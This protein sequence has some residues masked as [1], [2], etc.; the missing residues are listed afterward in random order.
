MNSYTRRT[1]MVSLQD[2][3]M[4]VLYAFF[5]LYSVGNAIGLSIPY[6]YIFTIAIVIA[7]IMF[8]KNTECLA[9]YKG[10][11]LWQGVFIFLMACSALWTINTTH[12]H[13]Q[14]LVMFKI[15]LKITTVVII[16]GDFQGVQKLLA[17]FSG[18]GLAIFMTLFATGR[19]YEGWRLGTDLLG[20][21]NSF[22]HIVTIMMTG[23][24]Y[25]IFASRRRFYKMVNVVIMALDLY[26]IFLSGGRKFII[27]AVVFMFVTIVMNSD[28]VRIRNVV[29]A[30]LTIAILVVIGY[31]FIMTND[32]LYRTIGIRLI[33]LG[34]EEGA[35]G[36][37]DQSRLMQRGI[38][39]FLQRPL[40]GFGIGGFQQYSYDYYGRYIYAHSNYIEL[41]ADFGIVG[42]FIYYS[43]YFKNLASMFKCY[44]KLGDEVKLYLPLMLAILVLDIFSISF[45]QT[46]FIPFF[47]MLISG[48]SDS[49]YT[50]EIDGIGEI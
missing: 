35:M 40:F 13:A 28:R 50:S 24:M 46:A 20:N 29:L 48:Y 33:G 9:K 12:W 26:L 31:R 30:T 43:R 45:N 10:F 11:F 17:G 18:L 4:L 39:M 8:T 44:R 15:L 1:L 34:T 2:I 14:L 5:Y 3:G 25:Y 27:Y 49:K 38:E 47:V 7:L 37:G 22:A 6:E 36:V 21:A 16:C 23:A 42:F 19:L 32:V 41:L